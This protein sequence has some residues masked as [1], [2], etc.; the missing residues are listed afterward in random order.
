L[1]ADP[2]SIDEALSLLE[3]YGT[4]AKL[5]AGGQS[6][7]PLINMRLVRPAV[8]IDLNRVVGLDYVT[9]A[10]GEVYIGAM[11]R[12]RAAERS[13]VLSQHAPLLVEALR[14]VGHPQIRN[15]GTIGGSLAHA[16]PAA[17]LPAVALALDARFVIAGPRGSRLLAAQDFFV[18]YLR[19]ALDP[20]ELLQE[21]Q[22]PAMAADAGYA[23]LEVSRRHG[24][25]AIV[26][27]AATVRQDALRRCTDVRMVFTGVGATPVRVPEAEAA[28]EGR[29]LNE[30]VLRDVS[31]IVAGRLEPDSDIHASAAYRKHLAGVLAL[32]ALTTAAKRTEVVRK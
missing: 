14:W 23:F 17:E 1:Y 9:A 7:M 30:H 31:S 22:I 12:Q 32:R 13:P 4:E 24:D 3:E 18:S 15:R 10:N 2:S 5:L 25:F 28:L 20:V 29:T 27:I 8:L 11:V 6:L 21:I 26:G 16:D 19:T